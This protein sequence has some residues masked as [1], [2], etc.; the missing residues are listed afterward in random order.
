MS[1]H[2]KEPW[3]VRHGTAVMDAQCV[4]IGSVIS[5]SRSYDEN[6]ANAKRVV[7]CVNA[8]AGVDQATLEAAPSPGMVLQI[9]ANQTHEL[10][11]QRDALLSALEALYE[12]EGTVEWTGIGEMPS[13]GL[14]Q[15]RRQAAKVMEKIR[16]DLS[17]VSVTTSRCDQACP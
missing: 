3:I 10:A 8:C 13:E 15:A 11:A 12:H 9:I 17:T 7:A 2:T 16:A 6:Q 4:N 14:Q 1:R 5:V